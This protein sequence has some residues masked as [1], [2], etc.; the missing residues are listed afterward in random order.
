MIYHQVSSLLLH[1]LP[2]L[3]SFLQSFIVVSLGFISFWFKWCLQYGLSFGYIVC[4]FC[5]FLKFTCGVCLSNSLFAFASLASWKISLGN[6]LLGS[7]LRKILHLDDIY[8]NSLR[9]LCTHCLIVDFE[10]AQGI[11]VDFLE[12]LVSS[13]WKSHIDKVSK[14]PQKNCL[15]IKLSL[16][17]FPNLPCLPI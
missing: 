13:L 10:L 12:V 7:G 17:F 3:A 6:A 15:S 14:V 2:L 16:R 9:F 5:T 8:G 1:N 4:I 11:H